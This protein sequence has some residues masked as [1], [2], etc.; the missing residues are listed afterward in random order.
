METP[1]LSADLM[2]RQILSVPLTLRQQ[3]ELAARTPAT[4]LEDQEAIL[5]LLMSKS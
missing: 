3:K 5:R 2:I 4:F 1:D